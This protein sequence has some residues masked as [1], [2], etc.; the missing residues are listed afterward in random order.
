M[1]L[2]VVIVNYNVKHFLEQC[3]H[4]VLKA[5]EM[6]KSEIFV[7]DNASVDGSCQMI[8]K[9]FPGVKLIENS[10]NAGFSAANN[11][12][13]KEARGE[14]ILLLNPDTVVE[15]DTFTKTVRFM[16][17]HP[18]AGGL[19][20]KMIN[21]KG[22]FLPESKRGLPTPWVAFYKIFGLSRLFPRSK[23]FGKYHLTY[24]NEN[25]THAVDVLC[26]AF[27]MLRKS[28]LTETGLLDESYF[29]YGEDIDLSYRILK[30]GYRNYYFPGTTIIHYKGESTTKES[31]K[32]VKMF[33]SSMIIFARKH[34][35]PV[36][37]G[38]FS[39]LIH[40]AVWFRAGIAVLGRFLNKISL[41]LLDF[42][43]SYGGFALLL[44]IWENLMFERGYYPEF[45]MKRV[46][47]AYLLFWLAGI[48]I[49]GGYRK[50]VNIFK[51]VKGLFWGTIALMVA[52]AMISEEFRFSRAMIL[53]GSLFS[54][55]V[56]PLVRILFSRMKIPGFE[57]NIERP[58]KIAIAGVL[59]EAER[60]RDLLSQTSVQPLF[61]GYISVHDK[62][63][64]D[65]FLGSVSQLKE[66]I[67]INHIE[68]I[69]FCAENMSSGE[70]IRAMIDLTETDVDY[71]IAPPES[72][73]I[74][75][76]NSINTSGD[77]YLVKINT[78]V[79]RENRRNKRI[80]DITVALFLLLFTWIFIWFATNKK[81]LLMNTLQVLSG[82]KSWVGYIPGGLHD[83]ELPVIRQGVLNP[84][85]LF[86]PD[87]L[88]I[89]RIQQINILYAKDYRINNDLALIFRFF[90]KLDSDYHG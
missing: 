27:M 31:I 20:V 58:K 19:G 21:G 44:P 47:P 75:G 29:M 43:L 49:S 36:H 17:E 55:L 2:S 40:A 22:K 62:H 25:E 32:Y 45:Y 85:M 6:V 53:I 3:L 89:G 81:Q 42:F 88:T 78:L 82:R 4:S 69:I 34:F 30:T 56:L 79:R 28:V 83:D 8:R 65:D 70:I 80:L 57:L 26:G 13:I 64:S 72:Y 15:E 54:M 39:F 7:I 74:I 71:K 87:S 24:L 18:E 51:I 9:K 76:S 16:D 33:Y 60:V 77:L 12:A 41:P 37:A 50:P 11:Q 23:R 1:K 63:S 48:Q 90:N 10:K 5:S 67:R 61:A 35:S 66:I 38:A 86:T 46:V 84:G 59:P 14:Y 68:E 52:Y 73:S